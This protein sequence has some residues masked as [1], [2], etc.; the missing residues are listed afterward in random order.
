MLGGSEDLFGSPLSIF[1]DSILINLKSRFFGVDS[2]FVLESG[3]AVTSLGLDLGG[4][5]SCPAQHSVF[6]IED[7][8]HCTVNGLPLRS[9]GV[10][11]LELSLLKAGLRLLCPPLELAEVRLEFAQELLDLTFVV[12]LSA[13]PK[14]VCVNR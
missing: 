9:T 2:G 5:L 1:D 14:L 3:G 8:D 12:A 11:C 13:R 6:R 10:L 7:S 4:L